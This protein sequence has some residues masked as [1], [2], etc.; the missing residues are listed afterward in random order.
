MTSQVQEIKKNPEPKKKIIYSPKEDLISDENED[1]LEN[2]EITS[3]DFS[4][5]ENFLY[6][7]LSS[8]TDQYGLFNFSKKETEYEIHRYNAVKCRIFVQNHTKDKKIIQITI[9]H[10][11]NNNIY[12]TYNQNNCQ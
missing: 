8:L 2:I 6:K 7:N 9:L 11:E 4:G 12:E 5:I 10:L 3:K 1:K